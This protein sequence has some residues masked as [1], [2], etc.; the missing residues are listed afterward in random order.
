MEGKT[1]SVKV[2]YE[3][4]S[5]GTVLIEKLMP[6]TPHEMVTMYSNRGS[7]VSAKH[8]CMLGNQPEMKLKKSNSTNY[9]FELD[10]TKGIS[11]KNEMHMHSIALSIKG[12]ELKQEWTNYNQGKKGEVAVFQFKKKN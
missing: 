11:D 2:T 10:G 5:G 7:T 1:E 8:Y 3:L 6:G 4:T 12:N 9:Q